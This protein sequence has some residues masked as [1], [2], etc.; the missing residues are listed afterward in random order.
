ME[1]ISSI[2][3]VGNK[4]FP[5]IGKKWSN[6]RFGPRLQLALSWDQ[7]RIHVLGAPLTTWRTLLIRG[8][9][10]KESEY[11]I[12]SGSLEARECNTKDFLLVTDLSDLIK[13]PLHLDANRQKDFQINGTTITKHLRQFYKDNSPIDIR[14]NVQDHYGIRIISNPFQ[15]TINELERRETR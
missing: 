2:I 14:L 13:L 7:P 6:R 9:G 4:L 8:I 1:W 3:S 10:G 5:W 15:V 11:E 12:A